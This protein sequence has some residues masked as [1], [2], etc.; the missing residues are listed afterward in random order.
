MMRD[1]ET[2]Q[3]GYVMSGLESFLEPYTAAVLEIPSLKREL[4][5]GALDA[6]ELDAINQ[7]VELTDAKLA[8]A[9]DSIAARR[10]YGATRE[11]LFAASAVGK[12]QMDKLR[13]LIGRQITLMAERRN[14][15]RQTLIDGS[16]QVAYFSALAGAINALLLGIAAFN[17]RRLLRDRS[18]AADQLK[19]AI[20]SAELRNAMMSGSARMLQ[21]IDSVHALDDTSAVLGPCLTALLPGASGTVYLYRNSN[22]VLEPL[23]SWGAEAT[24]RAISPED[25]WALR[26]G[27]PHDHLAETDLCCQH[28][29]TEHRRIHL[30]IPMVTQGAVL[31]L[32]SVTVDRLPDDNVE[33]HREL[34]TVLAEQVSLALSNVRLREALREQSIIDPLTGLYNRRFMEETLKRELARAQRS[35]QPLSVIMFDIDHFK[36]V[37]DTFGHGAGDAVLGSVAAAAK[38]TIRSADTICRYG[39]EEMIVLMPACA[40]AMAAERAEMIRQAIQNLRIEHD[41]RVIPQV[42][43]SFG[44]ASH[45]TFGPD[46]RALVSAADAALY[47]AKQ[48][49]RNNVQAAAWPGGV[50]EVLHQP[51]G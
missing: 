12:A 1:V 17:V 42:T 14:H 28:L 30:C 25:C 2:G 19:K 33:M 50:H 13:L 16:A 21:A 51:H 6:Q 20:T 11:S 40:E 38:A 47:L 29:L 7:I 27:R 26:L 15:A 48:H 45:P 18:V 24:A 3:N 9:A 46:G 34:V 37:N 8:N 32:M 36:R 44:V 43:A 39:G 49:G 4:V 10:N 5:Q 23:A 22:D 31:G 41:G 35:Q